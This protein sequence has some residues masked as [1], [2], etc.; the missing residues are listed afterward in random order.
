M[1]KYMIFA[2]DEYEP[3]KKVALKKIKHEKE[4]VAF[5]EDIT[6]L[7][8]YGCMTVVKETNDGKF[9]YSEGEWIQI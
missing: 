3:D 5:A 8:K 9:Q 6:N 1:T 7:K 2:Q 4:A